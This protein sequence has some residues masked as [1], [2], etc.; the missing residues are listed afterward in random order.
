MSSDSIKKKYRTDT[1]MSVYSDNKFQKR[2]TLVVQPTKEE[3][4]NKEPILEPGK[5]RAREDEKTEKSPKAKKK[6]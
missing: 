2:K 5:K 4:E 6:V 1:Y 3:K